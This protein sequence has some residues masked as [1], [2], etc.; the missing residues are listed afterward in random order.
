MSL[1]GKT[2][3][4][5]GAANGVGRAC[6]RRL[7]GLGAR[8]VLGDVDERNAASLMEDLKDLGG[9]AVF[10]YCD[11]ADRL[12]VRNLLTLGLEAYG[13]IDGMINNAACVEVGSFLEIDEARFD[14]ALRVNLR[15]AFI[16]GQAAAKQ[17][18]RQI[19]EAR[20]RDEADDGGYAIV[21][22]SSINAVLADPLMVPVAVSKGGLNQLTKAMAVALAPYGIR[23]NA[24]GPGVVRAS[25]EE[26][27][28]T[29]DG[30]IGEVLSHTP[31]GRFAEPNEIASIATFL[32][33][34]ESSY[35]T[36]QCIYADGGRL[37]V[38]TTSAKS[39]E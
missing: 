20:A 14:A 13:R 18:V 22:I 38:N 34:E 6:A 33:S 4:V 25:L 15:G 26:Q 39:Q 17:M 29:V 2:I 32:V 23:V 27:R 16:V 8:L 19:E 31:L 24:V 28:H 21:H 7:A 36:G 10:H 30:D 9:S 35:V 12:D 37:A 3:M 11:V 1:T 5:M